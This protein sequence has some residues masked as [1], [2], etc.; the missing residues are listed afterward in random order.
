MVVCQ[1]RD[2]PLDRAEGGDAGAVCVLAAAS[3]AEGMQGDLWWKLARLSAKCFLH[4]S[5]CNHSRGMCVKRQVRVPE[6]REA[7]G[8]QGRRGPEGHEDAGACGH[9]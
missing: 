3:L 4:G 1:V 7:V 2:E 9:G 8:D 5:D 6:G